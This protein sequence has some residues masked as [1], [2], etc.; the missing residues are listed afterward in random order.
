MAFFSSRPEQVLRATQQKYSVIPGLT[1][2]PESQVVTFIL[3]TLDCRAHKRALAMTGFCGAFIFT[4]SPLLRLF[5]P[6]RHPG[7]GRDP[8]SQEVTFILTILDCRAHKRAL[9]ITGFCGTFIFTSS[10][11]LSLFSLCV[12]PAQAGIQSHRREHSF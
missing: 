4:S 10:P 9:A 11:L 5:F 7:A 3:T 12:I 8:E 2:D 1:R 6:L